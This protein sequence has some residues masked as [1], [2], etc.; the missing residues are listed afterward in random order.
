M[1]A[2]VNDDRPPP[3]PRTPTPQAEAVG[4]HRAH[5]AIRRGRAAGPGRPGIGRQQPKT[6]RAGA[7]RVGRRPHGDVGLERTS[8]PRRQYARRPDPRTS[9]GGAVDQPAHVRVLRVERTPRTSSEHQ[10]PQERGPSGDRADASTA[11][12]LHGSSACAEL[13][14]DARHRSAQAGSQQAVEAGEQGAYH[15]GNAAQ[16]APRLSP[17]LLP[18]HNGR[19]GDDPASPRSIVAAQH[20]HQGADAEARP[21]QER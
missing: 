6:G 21:T 4:D 2:A 10:T 8:T 13:E 19:R 11:P 18:S 17:H 5:R 14:R 7:Q 1:G 9:Y 15:I 3:V 20:P 12:A 16:K